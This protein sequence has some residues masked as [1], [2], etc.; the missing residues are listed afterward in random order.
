MT[1]L[2]LPEINARRPALL[3]VAAPKEAE[4]VLRGLGAG[5]PVGGGFRRWEVIPAR[6][7]F[8]VLM[9]GVGKACAA[10]A[11]AMALDLDRHSALISTGIA[12]ALPGAG[13]PGVREVVLADTSVYADE[14]IETP[15][16]FHDVASMGF[17]PAP[18]GLEAMGLRVGGDPAL[19]AALRGLSDRVGAIA[20]VSTCAGTD[21]GAS[22]I[23]ART[24]AVAEAMEGAAVGF[25]GLSVAQARRSAAAPF[26]EI[27]VISNTTGDRGAQR[28][29]LP[30][31]LDRLARLA[32]E[33]ADKLQG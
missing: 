19:L 32:G 9:T 4:A 14:G 21:G 20:T 10:G 27:R 8:E 28:W 3:V 15:D 29:D 2:T 17:S 12:G 26:A 1:D 13:A 7:G 22:R 24:G 11:V 6:P 18:P 31:A 33:M 25:T 30:G 5:D 16:G 23:A